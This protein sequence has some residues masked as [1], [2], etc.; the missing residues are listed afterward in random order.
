MKRSTVTMQAVATRARVSTSTVSRYINNKSVSAE[1]EQRVLA[2]IRDLSY[3]PNRV[4][5]S[6][7]IKKTMMIGMVIPDITNP[8]FPEVVKGVEDTARAAGFS[9]ML[10]NAGEDEE[11]QWE[12]LQAL[13]G[14]RCDGALLIMA[15]RGR[16]HAERRKELQHFSLPVVYVDR[17]PDFP[18]D[19][20]VVDN[21]RSAQEAV[22]HLVRLGHTRIAAI[23][24]DFDV[25]VHRDRIA[26]YR[27]VLA[28][29]R[30]P[31]PDE[32][33]VQA[34]PTVADGYSAAARLL[35]FTDPPSALIV[36]NSRMAIGVIAAIE[37]HG[38]RCPA[39]ISVVAYDS[40]EWQDVFHPRLTTVTQPTYLMG[41]RAADLLI[42]RITDGRAGAPQKVLLQ[43]ALTLR[44]S[45][46]VYHRL[47]PVT[48]A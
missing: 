25:S 18:A 22:R 26:G 45:I 28:E 38:L 10:F 19:T 23:T 2:A 42:A 4:A 41:A 27:Q 36:T 33:V 8:F 5:R 21:L 39:D 20:V 30:L 48:S 31:H 9:L 44:E 47:A 1:N 13:H 14:Q 7:R 37:S 40:H 46:D 12:C 3:S 24:V 32:W 43:A 11:R 6:L 29:A 16:H 17:A 35:A 34:P 15:P